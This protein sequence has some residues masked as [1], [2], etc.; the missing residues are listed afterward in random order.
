MYAEGGFHSCRYKD[1]N[2]SLVIKLGDAVLPYH[3]DFRF[4]LT[5]VIPNPHYPPEVSVKVTLLNFT[6]TP[7]GLQDQLLAATVEAERPDLAEKK[8]QLVLQSADNKRLPIG[9][10]LRA[11]L[12]GT[13]P[14]AL[15]PRSGNSFQT[16]ASPIYTVVPPSLA[17]SQLPVSQLPQ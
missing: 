9:A 7:D 6:I 17:V 2:G 8:N 1:A 10:R 11:K 16:L 15:P 14:A 13:S 5:T 12:D 3:D 4:A